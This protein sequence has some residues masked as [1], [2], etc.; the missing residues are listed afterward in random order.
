MHQIRTPILHFAPE[1]VIEKQFRDKFE[2]GQEF[3]RTADLFISADLK[4]DVEQMAVPSKSFSTVICNHVLEHVDDQK[5]L[6]ELYRILTEDGILIIS[7]PI[8]EG[9]NLTY[10]NKAITGPAERDLHFG[11]PDHMRYYGRDF[12]DR[13]SEAGFSCEEVTAEG[14]DVVKY[15]LLRGEKFFICKK[16]PRIS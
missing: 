1:Q 16:I 6:S 5:A 9:W 8:I 11:Q 14:E 12:R 10:E 3:Y 15:A 4:I 7:V 13:L 2:V